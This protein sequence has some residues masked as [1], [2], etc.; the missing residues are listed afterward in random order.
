MEGAFTSAPSLESFKGIFDASLHAY[1]QL[2]ETTNASPG[3]VALNREGAMRDKYRALSLYLGYVALMSCFSPKGGHEKQKI[4]LAKGLWKQLKGCAREA[5]IVEDLLASSLR[6]P[7]T[8]Y[9]YPGERLGPDS[10]RPEDVAIV[11]VIHYLVQFMLKSFSLAYLAKVLERCGNMQGYS[12]PVVAQELAERIL[13][14]LAEQD[15]L[16]EY[17]RTA[18]QDPLIDFYTLHLLKS[19]FCELAWELPTTMSAQRQRNALSVLLAE[20]EEPARSRLTHKLGQAIRDRLVAINQESWIGR[21]FSARMGELYYLDAADCD[22]DGAGEGEMTTLAMM[23]EQAR[24]RVI[25]KVNRRFAKKRLLLNSPESDGTGP[26]EFR[27][28][29]AWESHH[30]GRMLTVA[31]PPTP[32][33][34][35][36]LEGLLH[37]LVKKIGLEL[38]LGYPV[39]IMAYSVKPIYRLFVHLA[40]T[41]QYCHARPVT[42]A[43][44]P[45][46]LK[47]QLAQ[48]IR[49]YQ[50]LIPEMMRLSALCNLD[51]SR[52]ALPP[53]LCLPHPSKSAQSYP[54]VPPP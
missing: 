53:Q 19:I 41:L 51:S 29:L 18:I 38:I 34:M 35:V 26:S 8:L 40:Q 11:V 13:A 36:Y 42:S 50:L 39:A 15:V 24:K 48:A 14:L 20:L 6:A 21:I 46:P 16:A 32:Q 22:Q 52:V 9:R 10:G 4:R 2:R 17:L 45:S 23:E 43:D 3:A 37:S 27:R 47:E 33:D 7:P 44:T 1:I 28:S 12:D 30:S 31:I 49:H 54:K 5:S 25:H